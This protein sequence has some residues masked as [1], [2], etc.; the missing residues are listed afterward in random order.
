MVVRVY[1]RKTSYFKYIEALYPFK[2]ISIISYAN[3]ALR[4]KFKTFNKKMIWNDV[5]WF[6]GPCLTAFKMNVPRLN[7]AVT[8]AAEFDWLKLI[9]A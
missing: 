4:Q 8:Q 6:H 3:G 9:I 5:K 7:L 1:T 2:K